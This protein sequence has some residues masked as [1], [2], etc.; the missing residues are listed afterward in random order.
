MKYLTH[1]TSTSLAAALLAFAVVGSACCTP[2]KD[3]TTT[4]AATGTAT[5]GSTA[6]GTSGAAISDALKTALAKADAADKTEDKVVSNC[7]NCGLAMPGS[8]THVTKLAGYEFHL[9]SAHCKEALDKDG[10][11]L[12]LQT[13]ERIAK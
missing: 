8:A 1:R 13:V 7:L 5:T 2:N 4:P 11:K 6:A 9:C 10:E 12:V 3:A